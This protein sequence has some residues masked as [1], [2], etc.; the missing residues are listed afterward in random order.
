MALCGAMA[1][2]PVTAGRPDLP[3]T[4]S[5]G[6]CTTTLSGS[7]QPYG[8]LL[9]VFTIIVV[10]IVVGSEPAAPAIGY[11]CVTHLGSQRLQRS[12]Y[13]EPTVDTLSVHRHGQCMEMMVHS[14]IKRHITELSVR[15]SR[16]R[17]RPCR[18]GSRMPTC[19]TPPPNGRAGAGPGSWGVPVST[20]LLGSSSVTLGVDEP[21]ISTPS[22]SAAWRARAHSRRWVSFRSQTISSPSSTSTG[23]PLQVA[24]L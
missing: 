7:A 23:T 15:Y 22:A 20:L 19:F 10:S 18:R 6:E 5:S 3:V 17:L 1:S 11:S 9:G 16:H 4:A 12:L 13:R 8:G 24:D 21:R 2:T 14:D